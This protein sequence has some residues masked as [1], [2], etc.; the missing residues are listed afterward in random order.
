VTSNTAGA[1]A[2]LAAI[3]PPAGLSI[4][5]DGLRCHLAAMKVQHSAAIEHQQAVE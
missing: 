2:R 3:L 5:R 4:R 1:A